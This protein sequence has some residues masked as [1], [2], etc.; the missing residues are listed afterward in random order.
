MYNVLQHTFSLPTLPLITRDQL[1]DTDHKAEA[2][3]AKICKAQANIKES[4]E[5]T[6]EYGTCTCMCT[7]TFVY[8]IKINETTTHLAA[9]QPQYL[10]QA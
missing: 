2:V 5:R 4:K 6:Q 9:E 7:C 3:H 10:T 1:N 8:M